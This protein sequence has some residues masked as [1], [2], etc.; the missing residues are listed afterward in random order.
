[1]RASSCRAAGRGQHVDPFG[2]RADGRQH[3][4]VAGGVQHPAARPGDPERLRGR[5]RPH[6]IDDQQHLPPGQRLPQQARSLGG[7]PR[8][9]TGG[10]Q[11]GQQA[12]LQ[13]GQVGL[14]PRP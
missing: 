9:R 13:P 14:L 7:G 5:R 2:D 4:R 12:G 10:A 6:V 3:R 11:P 8:R 1:M